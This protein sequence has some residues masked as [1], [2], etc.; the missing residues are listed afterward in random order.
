M[1]AEL[2]PCPFCGGK[3]RISFKDYRFYG[4]NCVT[5]EKSVS[6]RV[7]VIC[8]KCKSRGKPIITKPMTNPIPYITEW[9]NCYGGSDRAK[10]ETERFRPYIEKAVE[11]WN[12]RTPKERS[13]E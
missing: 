10:A 2:L 12:T 9:G 5:H 7:Q 6:Y 8:N 3:A 4:W 13:E 1:M 11:A